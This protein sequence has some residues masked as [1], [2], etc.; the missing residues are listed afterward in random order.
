MGHW[1]GDECAANRVDWRLR[2][3]G[4]HPYGAL[5]GATTLRWINHLDHL[6]SLR[7]HCNRDPSAATSAGAGPRQ[8]DDPALVGVIDQGSE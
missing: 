8:R 5:G 2:A 7:E 6:A 3:G 1:R 4:G